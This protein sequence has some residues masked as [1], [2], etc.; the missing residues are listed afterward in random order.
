[1]NNYHDL[2]IEDCL[3]CRGP[4]PAGSSSA[5]ANV[6]GSQVVGMVQG[7]VNELE[8]KDAELMDLETDLQF[9]KDLRANLQYEYDELDA[10]C[11]RMAERFEES[12]GV[13][14]QLEELGAL[15]EDANDKLQALEDQESR[16]QNEISVLKKKLEDCNRRPY[17]A[18][19]E[20]LAKKSP[21]KKR[22]RR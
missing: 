16:L 21:I 5:V 9:Q 18:G 15:Y 11:K 10:R 17:W 3:E 14:Q 12:Q 7:L 2:L 4:P 19:A 1:M 20:V 22:M 13:E 6:S 8:S